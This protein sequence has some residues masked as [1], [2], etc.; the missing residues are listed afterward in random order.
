MQPRLERS[1][2]EQSFHFPFSGASES[3]LDQLYRGFSYSSSHGLVR[4]SL[5]G[6][7]ATRFTEDITD[8]RKV[9]GWLRV[10]LT[11]AAKVK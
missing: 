11:V 9:R 6:S 2:A 1:R 5:G 4:G 8:F 10:A 7:V 3:L